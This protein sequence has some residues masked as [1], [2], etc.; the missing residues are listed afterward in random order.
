MR[1]GTSLAKL[2][3]L[4]SGTM[5]SGHKTVSGNLKTTDKSKLNYNSIKTGHFSWS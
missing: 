5:G 4:F 3:T 1:I 2:K